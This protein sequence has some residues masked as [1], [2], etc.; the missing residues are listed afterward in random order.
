MAILCI[1]ITIQVMGISWWKTLL[2][3][4]GTVLASQ[5]ISFFSDEFNAT[6]STADGQQGLDHVGDEGYGSAS[7]VDGPTCYPEKD[8][9]SVQCGNPSVATAVSA[10]VSLDR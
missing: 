1:P 6:A 2:F 8:C 7:A 4:T 10:T 3:G 5:K 9:S